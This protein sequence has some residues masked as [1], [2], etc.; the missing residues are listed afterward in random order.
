MSAQDKNAEMTSVAST[1]SRKPE[2]YRLDIRDLIVDYDQ[3]EAFVKKS[4]NAIKDLISAEMRRGEIFRSVGPG[5]YHMVFPRVS[6]E[7]AALRSMTIEEKVARYIRAVKP[8]AYN[9]EAVMQRIAAATKAA[10]DL[11]AA[12]GPTATLTKPAAAP[13]SATRTIESLMDPQTRNQPDVTLTD[14]DMRAFAHLKLRFHPMWHVHNKLITGYRCVF[15]LNN[16]RV[17]YRDGAKLLNETSE[18]VLKA[19]FDLAVCMQATAHLNIMLK[20]GQKAL[21]IVPV[22]YSTMEQPRLMAPFMDLS[23][24]AAEEARKLL[25]FELLGVPVGLSRFKLQEPITQLRSR[26][27]ALVVRSGVDFTNFESYRDLGVHAVG[28]DASEYPWKEAKMIAFLEQFAAVAQRFR[29]QSF[30][31]GV[32][33]NS[34]TVAAVAS[35]YTYVDGPAIAA[36]LDSPERIH[37]FGVKSLY[38]KG[39]A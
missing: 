21:M 1:I 8:A 16:E 6:V 18:E 28:M 36:D 20:R 12:Q 2:L 15:A 32:P 14:A 10:A 19:K 33:T 5:V 38:D 3:R 24:K 25:V 4:D 37:S 27:R 13:L 34:L 39:P 23:A 11:R 31:H 30:V 17:S 35:G 9:A 7:L 26:C 29:L 22:H